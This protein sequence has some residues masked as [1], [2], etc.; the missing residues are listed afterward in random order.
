MSQTDQS[1]KEL[2]KNKGDNLDFGEVLSL[3][4]RRF[5]PEF[6]DYGQADNKYRVSGLIGN[7]KEWC[8]EEVSRKAMTAGWS[9]D[10]TGNTDERPF[11]DTPKVNRSFKKVGF[12]CV[13]VKAFS[14]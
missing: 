13:V 14:R 11:F 8:F 2:L 6:V 10:F 1:G 9:Y 4:T 3:N 7:V 12:R 5:K